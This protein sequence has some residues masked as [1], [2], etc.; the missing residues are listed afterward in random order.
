MDYNVKVEVVM[1]SQD[2]ECKIFA[3]WVLQQVVGAPGILDIVNLSMIPFGF[4][5]ASNGDGTAPDVEKN[6]DKEGA[7][8]YN[9]TFKGG[10][11]P[12]FVC[13]HGPSECEGNVL[14][15]CT[16][17]LYPKS[18]QWF[19]VN[20]CIQSRTCAEGEAPTQDAIA[21]TGLKLVNFT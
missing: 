5:R 17:E 11:P 9:V 10:A 18:E 8:R 7:V 16:Q 2:P 12:E 3:D 13:E 6:K 19:R 20:M 4:G 15:A 21:H 1:E 14:L